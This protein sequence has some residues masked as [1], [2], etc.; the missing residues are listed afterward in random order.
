VDR[1]PRCSSA[2][3]PDW[4]ARCAC[5]GGR[6]STSCRSRSP[7]RGGLDV[8]DLFGHIL[9]L[10]KITV[11]ALDPIE[12]AATFGDDVDAAYEGIVARMQAALDR[13]G[14]ERRWPV[15]G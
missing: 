15:I 12:V 1:R 8:G 4:P 2:A 7:R 13:L 9:L 6:G 10:A 11:E 5:T 3:A 14:A